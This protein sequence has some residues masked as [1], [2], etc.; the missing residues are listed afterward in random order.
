MNAVMHIEPNDNLVTCLRA[1]KKG[2]VIEF[3]GKTYTVRDDI[4][5][6]HKMSV[7][8]I[9][10]GEHCVKYGEI[11]G[12]ALQDIEPGDWVH[13]HNLDSERG[14]GDLVGKK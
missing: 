12:V 14:R 10:K 2:E 3:E 1:L 5:Q 7:A 4:P 8:T 11:I 13:V 6:F 9:K